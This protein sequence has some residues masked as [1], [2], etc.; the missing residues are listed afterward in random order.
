M[1]QPSTSA[2]ADVLSLSH[3]GGWLSPPLKRFSSC[4]PP[5]RGATRTVLLAPGPDPEGRGF[6]ALYQAIDRCEPDDILVIAGLETVPGAIWGQVLSRAARHVGVAGAIVAGGVRDIDLLAAEGVSVWGHHRATVGAGRQCHVV[7]VN[8]DVAI[9][10]VAVAAG[11]TVFADG[12]G[13]VVTPANRAD[14]LLDAAR[15]YEAA[16]GRVLE[17]L[18]AGEGLPSAYSHKREAVSRLQELNT[19]ALLRSDMPTTESPG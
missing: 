7:A 2:M 18:Q 10:G 17:A 11:D 13:V 12:D 16:E 15:A 8:V 3:L 4:T 5:L 14:W 6:E 19:R 1:T 9:A